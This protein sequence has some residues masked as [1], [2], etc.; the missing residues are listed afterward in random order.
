MNGNPV[1]QNIIQKSL[2]H[3]LGCTT[4]VNIW[5][6]SVIYD[7]LT[8]IERQ[9]SDATFATMLDCVRRGCPTEETLEQCVI[10]MPE[11]EK[12]IELQQSGQAV[13]N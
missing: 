4:A 10:G 2:L 11:S 5:K 9:K 3:K 1:F 12:F 13:S 7:E 8:I 6:D